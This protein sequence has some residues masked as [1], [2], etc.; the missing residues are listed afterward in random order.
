MTAGRGW[1]ALALVVFATW[2][3]SRVVI[4]AYLFGTISRFIIDVQGEATIF[5]ITNPFGAG[6]SATFFL[7]MLPYVL[8]IVVVVI[9][10]REAARKRVGAPA[11]LGTPYVRGQRGI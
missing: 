7:E 11:A 6:R 3:P 1:I 5:G 4:G 8:V 9:G 2:K 10:S